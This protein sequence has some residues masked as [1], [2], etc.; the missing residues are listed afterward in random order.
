MYK[1]ELDH[2]I[3]TNS[4]PKSLMFYGDDF[5]CSFYLKKVSQIIGEKENI[6]KFYHDE[7]NYESA[8]NFISQPSLFGDINTLI[9]KSSK[10]IPKKE[11]D[12]F[13]QICK[14]I[15]NSFFLFYFEGED[16]IAKDITKSFSKKNSANF[17]RFFKPNLNEAITILKNRSKKIGLDIDPFALQHLYFMQNEDISLSVNELH[18]LK[19][20]NKKIEIKDID[21]HVYSLGIVGIDELINELL[22]KKDIQKT[23]QNLVESALH[24]E[25]KIINA[26]QSYIVQLLM[27]HIYIKIHGKYD[28]KEILGYN[29]PPLLV[30]QRAS[31]SIKIKLQTYLDMLKHLSYAEYV[32]KKSQNL[33]KSSF[34]H[35]TLIKL[36]TFL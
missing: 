21:E 1:A 9:I 25:I 32:L 19:I 12:S 24:D 7:Y 15:P 31:M 26:L 4:L 5:L 30:K 18:K 17:V 14:K 34:L 33:E 6:L 36:Q 29:L 2:I 28:T 27:F 35:S 8:K 23:L 16:N 10:K 13:I 22:S 11:L 3:S 20:L